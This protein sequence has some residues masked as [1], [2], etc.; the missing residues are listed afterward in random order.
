MK[1]NGHYNIEDQIEAY[2]KGLLSDEEVESLWLDLIEYP[3]H[4]EYL[5]NSV[6]LEALASGKQTLEPA[7]NG[8]SNNYKWTTVLGRIAAVFVFAIGVLSMFYL[9][10]NDQQSE[11]EPVAEIEL[12]NFRT[13]SIPTDV[14]EYELQRAINLASLEHEN[15]ALD[16]LN[17]IDQLQ[18]SEEQSVRLEL[19]KG[20]VYYNK[21][22]YESAVQMLTRLLEAEHD[23]HLLTR[24]KIHWY[25]GNAYLQMNQEELAIDHIRITYELNGAYRRLAEQ[26][27]E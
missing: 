23:M 10:N 7:S 16:K 19:S 11:P 12:N 22:N 4:M 13:S 15:E 25:L 9:F 17:K 24:E 1:K 21:G 27:L 6:N 18:L 5:I 2:R 3:E 20:S 14:F 8:A 26:H